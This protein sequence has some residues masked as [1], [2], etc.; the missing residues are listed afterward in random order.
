LSSISIETGNEIFV[1]ENDFLIGVLHHT[2][3]RD[4]SEQWAIEIGRTIE[5]LGS[6]SFSNCKSLSSII[7]ESNSHLT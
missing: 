3:I 2:L 4:F 7:F 6:D 5:I 1:L